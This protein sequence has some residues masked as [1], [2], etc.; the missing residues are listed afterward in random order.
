MRSAE[1]VLAA[2]AV[3]VSVASLTVAGDVVSPVHQSRYCMGTMFDIVVY[4]PSQVIAERAIAKAMSEIVRLD[5]V[6]STFKPDSALSR[7]NREGRKGFV[8]VDPSLYEVIRESIRFSR[9]S[10]GRFDVT[11]APVL[12]T[13]KEAHADGRVPSK[14]ELAAAKQCVGYDK[15]ETAAPDR[16]RYRTDC[17]EIDLGGIGKGYAVDR[18]IAVLESAGIEH[19]L[20]NGGG[21]SI[22]AIG[23]SP[24]RDGWPVHLGTDVSGAPSVLL[25]NESVSTSQQNLVPLTFARATFGEIIDPRTSGP[26]INDLAVSVVARRA[27]S[28]DALSTAL[29]MLSIDEAR[30]VLAQF[31]DASAVWM[32]AAGEH[33]RLP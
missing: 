9:I 18:A 3:W 15:I 22:A 13:W 6:M 16:I 5:Q 1:R 8:P 4:H 25:R 10:G 12:K 31:P 14:A 17:M 2:I 11:I 30:A 29:L 23:T 7:L 28:S 33:A 19:A 32:S 21:S 24:G 26:V 20:V 27:T